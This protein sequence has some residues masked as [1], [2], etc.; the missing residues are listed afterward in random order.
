MGWPLRLDNYSVCAE[1]LDNY[2][3]YLGVKFIP[4][5]LKLRLFAL[6][7]VLL[8]LLNNYSVRAHFSVFFKKPLTS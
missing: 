4:K 3:L 5:S 7:F 8:P 2:P 6:F 1:V